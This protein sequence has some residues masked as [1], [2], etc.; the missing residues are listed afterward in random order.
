MI[1]GNGLPL[2]YKVNAINALPT[3]RKQCYAR[4]RKPLPSVAL[5]Y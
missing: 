5:E 3:G 4:I 1:K 2:R